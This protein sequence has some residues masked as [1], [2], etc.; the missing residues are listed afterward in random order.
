MARSTAEPA[1]RAAVTERP[2]G[3]G[4]FAPWGAATRMLVPRTLF[5]RSLLIVVLPLLILQ[6]VLAYIFYERHWDNVTQW[7]G[8]GFAGEVG[9]LID[10]IEQARS[11]EE[12]QRIIGSFRRNLDIT[13][14]FQAGARLPTNLPS[15]DSLL[16]NRVDARLR[17]TLQDALDRPFLLDALPE[18]RRRIALYVELE[19]GLLTIGSSRERIDSR[20]TTVFMFWM[21]GLSFGM[22]CV[23]MFLLRKQVRPIRRLAE[24]ADSFGKGR[25]VGDF[26]LQGTVEIRRAGVAFNRMRHRILRF[27]NQR[28]EMLAGVSH[29]LRTPL[30]RMKL[31]LAMSGPKDELAE[32]LEA[33]VLEMEAM[34]E[35]YLAFARGEGREAVV[36][37]DLTQMLDEIV[38]RVGRSGRIIEFAAPER[39]VIPLRPMAIRRCITN[40]VDNAVRHAQRIRISVEAQ[41]DTAVVTLDD[42]GPGIP[43]E[44]REAAFRVFYRLRPTSKLDAS[45]GGSGLGLT[46]ARDIVLGHGGD[47]DLESSPM[48][49]LRVVVRLPL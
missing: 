17:D 13:V 33:D 16:P 15:P 44:Q 4:G 29:D 7:L 3:R 21:A 30:T 26:R 42:D 10:L 27:I 1:E 48:G 2:A 22:V 37:T 23:A 39:L 34:V 49:G 25:D 19:N 18:R 11:L 38:E 43:P 32:E 20:T 14:H 6:A 46:I 28:T 41:Q 47:V 8:S 40:L 45:Q 9:A 31:A 24:A 35:A 36:P 12:Q 5:G